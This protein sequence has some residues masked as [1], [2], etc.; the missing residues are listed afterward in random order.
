[1]AM[2]EIQQFHATTEFGFTQELRADAE[3]TGAAILTGLATVPTCLQ[4]LMSERNQMNAPST[5]GS[6]AFASIPAPR[7]WTPTS[8]R[9][10]WVDPG[11]GRVFTDHMAVIAT[12]RAGLARRRHHRARAGDGRSLHRGA[13]LCAGDFRRAEG[14]A[15]MTA[16][17]H[18]SGRTQCAPLQQTAR[19]PRDA[20]T[21]RRAVPRIVPPIGPDRARLVSADRWRRAVPSPLHVCER[22]VPGREALRRISLHGHRLLGRRLLE[23]RRARGVD[24]GQPELHARRA[25]AAPARRSA[26]AITRQPRRAVGGD[27]ARM[28]PG[29]LPRRGRAPLGRGTGVA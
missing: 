26:A 6:A 25:R 3:D 10:G 24:L 12:P 1:M 18:C 5:A 16:A 23:G 27:R 15:W 2:A 20:R 28:R 22:G 7:R 14:L 21:A 29:R 4:P 13:A 8:A 19:A 11:F 9:R 17:W